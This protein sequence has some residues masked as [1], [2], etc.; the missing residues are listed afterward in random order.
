[1]ESCAEVFKHSTSLGYNF[2]VLD[3]G[4]GFPGIDN[5]ELFKEEAVVIHQNLKLHFSQYNHLKVLAEP[6]V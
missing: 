2:T 1:M 4:G 3:I 6:G 5:L